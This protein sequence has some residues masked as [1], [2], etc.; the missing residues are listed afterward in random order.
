MQYFTNTHNDSYVHH[1]VH[2]LL[3][4]CVDTKRTNPLSKLRVDRRDIIRLRSRRILGV[5]VCEDRLPAH[6]INNHRCARSRNGRAE[7]IYDIRSVII[8]R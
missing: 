2:P 5:L 1:D 3:G 7:S 4:H 6:S 8:P